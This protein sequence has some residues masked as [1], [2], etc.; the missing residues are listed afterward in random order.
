VLHRKQSRS[1]FGHG[2]RLYNAPDSP[3]APAQVHEAAS[4]GFQ[5]MG[6]CRGTLSG[7]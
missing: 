6:S 3:E 1:D 5:V 4:E 2:A 7:D